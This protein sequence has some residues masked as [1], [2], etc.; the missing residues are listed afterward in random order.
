MGQGPGNDVGLCSSCF[1]P[2][3]VSMHDPQNKALRRRIERRYLQQILTGCGKSWC[4]NEFCKN[5]RNTLGLDTNLTTK[6]A[7]PMIKPFL[8]GLNKGTKRATPLHF[9]VDE[10]SQKRKKLAELLA[11][12]DRSPAS[13]GGYNYEW[14]LGALEAESGSLDE[15]RQWLKNWAPTRKDEA[16]M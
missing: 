11:A 16:R 15:A 1:G 9:C 14:C 4:R 12:E 3:Y 2:L 13:H 8:D 10:G 5:G 6:D 7:L